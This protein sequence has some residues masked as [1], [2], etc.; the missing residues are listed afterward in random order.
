MMIY[1]PR[2]F[3]LLPPRFDDAPRPLEAPND[4][5]DQ[6]SSAQGNHY[7]KLSVCFKELMITS[8]TTS[9]SALGSSSAFTISTSTTFSNY[10]FFHHINDFIF[11]SKEKK[12]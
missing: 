11:V 7:C 6:R 5:V 1:F 9:S 3:P 8:I 4:P 10:F 2:G 12:S